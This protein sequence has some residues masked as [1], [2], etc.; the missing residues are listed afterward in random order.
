MMEILKDAAARSDDPEPKVRE[1]SEKRELALVYD[2]IEAKHIRGEVLPSLSGPPRGAAMWGITLSGREY[3]QKLS[4][5]REAQRLPAKFA[6]LLWVVSGWAFG[7]L[8]AAI[9]ALIALVL[10][11]YYSQ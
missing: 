1:F 10:K 6:K 2:F 4:V 5:E 11:H 8:T 3:L 7:I 9:S